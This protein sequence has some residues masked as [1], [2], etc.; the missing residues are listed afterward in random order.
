MF[1]LS[2]S[3]VILQTISNDLTGIGTPSPQTML[4][5]S[6][7]EFITINNIEWGGGEIT[8]K[9]PRQMLEKWASVPRL[10]SGIVCHYQALTIKVFK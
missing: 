8:D 10:F 5:T 2:H 9:F 6:N 7:D 1:S 3:Q 4:E